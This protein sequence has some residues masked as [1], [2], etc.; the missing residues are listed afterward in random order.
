M[1]LEGFSGPPRPI[2]RMIICGSREWTDVSAIRRELL[3]FNRLSCVISG[4]ARGADTIAHK[5]AIA[6][7][8]PAY[9]MPADWERH[10]KAAGP[11]RNQEMLDLLLAGGTAP[12][13]RS[14]DRHVREP[15]DLD[16]FVV[17]AFH[18]FLQNSKGTKD[19]V[20][21]ANM[22]GVRTEVYPA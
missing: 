20:T 10:G 1:I 7:G 16:A 3:R 2:V 18:P 5:L 11:I 4:G 19:M 12:F 13:W 21:R 9:S 14:Q 17:L 6:W 8:Y 22:A 15:E